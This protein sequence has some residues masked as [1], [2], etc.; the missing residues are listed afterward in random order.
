MVVVVEKVSTE[1][2]AGQALTGSAVEKDVQDIAEQ[3]HGEHPR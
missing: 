3:I 2:L 1:F